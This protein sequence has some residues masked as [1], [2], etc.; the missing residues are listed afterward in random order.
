MTKTNKSYEF[1][2]HDGADPTGVR[3]EVFVITNT[4]KVSEMTETVD[5][6]VAYIT[7][8]VPRLKHGIKGWVQIESELFN[9]VKKAHETQEDVKFRIEL[10]RKANV[11]RSTPMDELRV[12]MGTANANIRRILT[13]VNGVV[14]AEALTNPKEDPLV[15]D[16]RY[17]AGDNEVNTPPS[18]PVQAQSG[19]GFNKHALLAAFTAMADSPDSNKNIVEMLSAL[20]ISLGYPV[21]KIN[22]AMAGTSRRMTNPNPRTYKIEAPPYKEYNSDGRLNLG[23]GQIASGVGVESFVSRNILASASNSSPHTPGFDELV[24]YFTGLAYSIADYA[25]EKS[26]GSGVPADRGANSH[27]R[28]RG[29]FIDTVERFYPFPVAELDGKLV[30]ISTDAVKT[31]TANVGNEIL[32]RFHNAI[33]A[34]RTRSTFAQLFSQLTELD[35]LEG[36]GVVAP[37]AETVEAPVEVQNN[38]AN[39]TPQVEAVKPV[40]QYQEVPEPVAEPVEAPPVAPPVAQPAP[41]NVKVDKPVAVNSADEAR[42][43]RLER[44]K[45]AMNNVTPE[46]VETFRQETTH[47]A[48]EPGEDENYG[49]D[50]KMETLPNGLVKM[51][52]TQEIFNE[53]PTLSTEEDLDL[54][55]STL[56]QIGFN[57]ESDTD[58]SLISRILKFTYGEKYANAKLI[59]SD[60]LNAFSDWYASVE[61]EIVEELR[62]AAS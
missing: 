10:Q 20:L 62:K 61:P 33:D 14:S 19:A 28:I 56:D 37:V 6:G 1:I 23:S 48:I 38:V 22:E 40:E 9:I 18:Q 3:A 26:Y 42:I 5:K 59:P 45:A 13:E 7:F 27:T 58:R 43:E 4:G 51:T 8:A 34:S 50:L 17:P 29:I 30:I 47:A 57:L 49:D 36:P 54:F 12:D 35:S 53:S 21:E 55:K 46:A 2:S 44:A 41:T 31:W 39:P 60:Y 15:A 32:K 52:L 11:D 24:V 16:G 25:Q